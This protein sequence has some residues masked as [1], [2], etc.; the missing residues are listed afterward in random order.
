MSDPLI[1]LL[2]RPLRGIMF[3]LASVLVFIIM[4][5]LIKVVHVP[6]GETVFFRSAF[7]IPVIVVWLA[8][9][10]QLA[11][12]FAAKHPVDH[13]WRG[14]MGTIAMGLGFAGLIGQGLQLSRRDALL[15]TALGTASAAFVGSDPRDGV[16][17][18]YRPL[19]KV[20]IVRAQ[21]L[22]DG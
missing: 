5:S 10:G 3:K 13:I 7:A 6:A 12:G 1:P 15:V 21:L 11:T 20:R 19:K 16:D 18:S 14:L 17:L 9:Q 22:G 8:L 4:Q 2:S